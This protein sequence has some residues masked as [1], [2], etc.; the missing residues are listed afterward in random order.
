MKTL[1]HNF[2]K[3]IQPTLQRFLHAGIIALTFLWGNTVS[4]NTTDSDLRQLLQLTEYIGVDYPAAVK[5]G[6]VIDEG[7]YAEMCEFSDIIATK[8][9][10]LLQQ[11]KTIQRLSRQLKSAIKTRQSFKAISQLTMDLKDQ[12][13]QTAPELSL[14]ETLLSQQK[15]ERLYQSNC[16]DCH[17]KTG[18][19]DGKLANNM[20]PEPVDFTDKTR[21]MNRSIIGLFDVINNGLENT[22]MPSFKQLSPKQ[23][24]SLTFYVGSLAF[25]PDLKKKLKK[26]NTQ[27]AD[28]ALNDVIMY[29]PNELIRKKHLKNDYMISSLRASPYRLFST[30]KSPLDITRKQLQQS[31]IAYKKNNLALAKKLAVSAYLDGFELIENNL[32][33]RD[34]NLRK[35]I[36]SNLLNLRQNLNS[37]GNIQ[38]ISNSTRIIFS[39]LTIAEKLLS[40]Q[41]MSSVTLFSASLIILLRE[42]LEALLVVLALITILLKSNKKEA[43]KYV[44][45][46]WISALI[47]GIFTWFAAQQLITISGASREIME[48]VAA[49]IAAVVLFY[50]GFWMHSKSNSS[51]W[52][53]YIQK[54]IHNHLNAGTLWGIT[55]LAFIAVYR[56]VFET[57]LF[58]ESL[59]TQT[60]SSQHFVF[61]SGF[62]S[63]VFILAL[64]SWALIK[65]S[66]KL[67]LAKFFSSTTIIL[68]ALSFVL[69]GKA[70]SALQEAAIISIT[71]L[72]VRIEIDWLGIYPTWQGIVIQ[73]I[74]LLLSTT[75]LLRSKN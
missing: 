19:G 66:V 50:V 11:N 6:Q 55:A 7:E 27:A 56:E 2:L 73:L 63:A 64:I 21:A 59:L 35:K 29:S 36:E 65:Y 9:A 3:L 41:S 18:H 5:D 74:I 13:L 47:A 33:T 10:T 24:W 62:L 34:K 48:G 44:H 25:E 45:Y 39:D 58:Y 4:A 37:T 23:R 16:S 54:N 49:L 70:I 75:L 57:V 32:D 51:Q 40:Q 12:M 42:G 67:P 61:I 22:A 60:D 20:L 38:Q 8:T 14:P 43:L 15:I 28:L 46:G 1:H 31:V 72:P 17:G 53:K 71:P 26:Q 69:A 68:L 52:Q 30:D